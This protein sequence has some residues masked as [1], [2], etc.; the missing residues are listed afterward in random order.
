MPL[1]D[2]KITL[3]GGEKLDIDNISTL[4]WFMRQRHMI[5]HKR[6]RDIPPPWTVDPVLQVYSFTNVYRELD[7][8]TIWFRKNVRG[9]GRNSRDEIF[10]TI[11]FRF[12]N[13]PSSFERILDLTSFETWDP[14]SVE[15]QMRAGGPPYVTGAYIIKTPTG[16]DKLKGV[17]RC[18]DQAHKILASWNVP[19]HVDQWV[20]L[21]RAHMDLKKFPYLGGFMAYEVVSDLRWTILRNARDI[22]LWAF[23][24]PGAKRG[25]NRVYGR[26]LDAKGGNEFFLIKMQDLLDA[27]R[28]TLWPN[29]TLYPPLEMR[30]IEH[31]LCEYDKW[32][33]MH[34]EPNAR[35][36]Q[37]FTPNPEGIPS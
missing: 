1:G 36:R 19:D 28:T 31:S 26:P 12:F 9:K 37:K 23:A 29:D 33:R 32:C 20:T 8:V 18:I 2:K 14:Y 13:R 15:K 27:S 16:M 21:E 17:I 6:A 7:R 22:D 5:W 25:V 4:F 24:G 30:E 35:L 10:R 11:A 3:D 34:T